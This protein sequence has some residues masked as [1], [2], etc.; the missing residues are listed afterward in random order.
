MAKYKLIIV[1]DVEVHPIL[2][3]Q[4]LGQG[5]KEAISLAVKHRSPLIIDDD[6]AKKYASIF[7]IEAHGTLYIIYL[8]CR[9]KLIEK[10]DSINDLRDMIKD[11]FYISA[12]VYNRFLELLEN[13]KK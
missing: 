11:G 9:K 10:D 2:K 8:A 1:E 13:L 12:E 7:G 5:E 3:T 4:N 6:S